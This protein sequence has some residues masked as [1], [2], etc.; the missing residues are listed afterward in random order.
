MQKFLLALSAYAVFASS[1]SLAAEPGAK[2][3]VVRGLSAYITEGPD[4]A[5][6]A[7]LKGSGMEGNMQALTQA[8]N[9]RQIEDFY[10][11]PE[12]YDVVKVNIITPRAE[13]IVFSINHN[14]GI[15]FGRLQAYRTK[16][17]QWVSTEFKFSTDAVAFLPPEMVFGK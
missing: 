1:S 14:K 3:L 9:L 7:W 5:I 4:A 11:K 13:M 12:S 2:A 15:V 17:G 8:N 10:G 16:S 6:K